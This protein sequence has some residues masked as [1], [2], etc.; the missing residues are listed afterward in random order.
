MTTSDQ[1]EIGGITLDELN[2]EIYSDERRSEILTNM[3]IKHECDTY[4]ELRKTY[5][6]N[7]VITLGLL[8]YIALF[9]VEAQK[10]YK[11]VG[12]KV[13]VKNESG[14]ET[15]DVRLAIKQFNDRFGKARKKVIKIEKQEDDNYKNQLR[16]EFLKKLGVHYDLSIIYD[17]NAA[18][19]NTQYTMSLFEGQEHNKD[20]VFLFGKALGQM[21]GTIENMFSKI[22]KQQTNIKYSE[23]NWYKKDLNTNRTKMFV[24]DKNEDAAIQ[25]LLLHTITSINFAYIEVEKI[26]G[27]NTLKTRIQ[28][29]AMYYAKEMIAR[30]AEKT[31]SLDLKKKL[32]DCINSLE[33][34]FDV[35]FRNCLMHY[36]FED[37]GKFLIE[38]EFF[39]IEKEFFGLIESRYYGMSYETFMASIMDNLKMIKNTI[40]G[41]MCLDISHLDYFDAT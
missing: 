28:Y 36:S 25:L 20:N 5:G 19:S 39:D 24:L 3:V 16:F 13:E 38:Q 27:E 10:F 40:E 33:F 9:S 26:L 30:V 6:R 1:N 4:V 8:P 35:T 18:V 22:G 21:L 12:I 17:G 23:I 34:V 11:S 32:T 2:G 31:V 14:Y 29:L 7:S 15:K 41:L 37:E